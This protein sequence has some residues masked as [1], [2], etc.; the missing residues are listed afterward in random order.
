MPP[1]K[2]LICL[3][4][5][6]KHG[7]FCFA[8]IDIDTGRWVRPVSELDDGR[9]E[10]AVMSVDGKVPALCDIVEVPLAESGPDFGFESENL[11]IRP[12][13]WRVTGTIEPGELLRRC[14]GERHILHNGETHVTMEYLTAL[15]PSRRCTLQLVEGFEFEA[16]STGPSAQGGSKWNGSFVT[17]EGQRLCTRITDPVLLEKLER[18][19]C[20]AGH[21][22]VTVSLSMP[23]TPQNWSGEGTPCWKLI[24]G[25]VE[26]EP[27]EWTVSRGRA[28][29]LPARSHAGVDRERVTHTLRS[30]FGFDSF[31][32]NQRE[33]IDALTAGRDC[34]AVMPTGGGKSLCFQLPALLMKG[35]CLVISPLISLMKDQVDA[36]CATGIRAAYIN[37]A[38]TDRER[39]GVFEDLSRGAVD[40]LYVSPE[41]LSMESFL[42]TLGRAHL[43]MAAI[44]EAHCVSEWGH[45]FRPEY[46]F[47]GELVKRFP[48][49]PVAAFTATATARVQ[50]DIIARL[51]LRDPLLVRA[52]FDR[53]NLRYR[54]EPKADVKKQVADFITGS[55]RGSGIVYRTTRDD[56]EGTT[57]YLRDRGI[58]ALPYH[59]GLDADERQR[60]QEAFDRD[61]VEVVVATI[62][63]GMGIDKPNVRFVLHGDLPKNMEAY[64]QE[65]GRA[66]RDGDEA[67]CVLF[68][69][70]G[71]ASRI[72]YFIDKVESDA[73]RRRL[74]ASL[75]EMVD[76]A[77]NRTLCRR[78]RILAYFGETY[79]KDACGACDVCEAS[80]ELV[81]VTADGLKV[82]E[83]I[84]QTGERFGAVH[85]VDIVK[86]ANTRRIRQTRHN[87]LAVYGSGREHGKEYWR[88]LM[89][90]MIARDI[91]V[92]TGDQYPVVRLGS[93][94]WEITRGSQRLR[95]PAPTVPEPVKPKAEPPGHPGADGLFERLR[96]LRRR[97]AADRGVPPYV[98]FS[99]RTLRDMCVRMPRGPEQMRTVHGVGEWKLSTYG[100]AFL[101]EINTLDSSPGGGSV[102]S[103]RIPPT[104]PLPARSPLSRG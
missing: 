53:P 12:G 89:E 23:Y 69:G 94:A 104:D 47:L 97:L 10:R 78:A 63:F 100:E 58:E 74:R 103:Q 46:L 86:G 39:I 72:R 41:R 81:D 57:E 34:F 35:C 38:Q 54:V 93:R 80:G 18:G 79:G 11:S 17:P 76:Y 102:D 36:A 8:G 40:L 9:V 101:R 88:C 32:P 24:A 67:E 71:D 21:C 84:T 95:V 70:R 52:S 33:I 42:S 20:P 68:F 61:E 15:P 50:N 13:P 14:S 77:G 6:R 26:L 91:L 49:V 75:N 82:I 48:D 25:V 31:R 90:D 37:S 29:I 28:D 5:S 7:A 98:V 60:N 4:N 44:D 59:A 99:D 83:A 3:A 55:S 19:Y 27:G 30:V 43:C 64:Y 51:G 92:R 73:E 1:V 65:T 16:F 85:V 66:G 45:D 62:A 2:K 96:A 22:L 87:E 56:V